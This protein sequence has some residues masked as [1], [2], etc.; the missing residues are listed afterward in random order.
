[1][2][3]DPEPVIARLDRATRALLRVRSR[4]W[5]GV[6]EWG[7]VPEAFLIELV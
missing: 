3:S 2:R 5:K 6:Q 4:Y 1:M 7:Q